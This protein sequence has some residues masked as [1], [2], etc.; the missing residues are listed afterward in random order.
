MAH[1]I[2]KNSFMLYTI[3]FQNIP[4]QLGEYRDADETSHEDLVITL[5]ARFCSFCS[6]SLSLQPS[7]S[8][9]GEQ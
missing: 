8:Q 1:L 7:P 9:T 6:F 2:H 3:F 4:S 5:A